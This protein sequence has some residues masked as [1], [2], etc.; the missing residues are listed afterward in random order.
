MQNMVSF[1]FIPVSSLPM[2]S[3]FADISEQEVIS[4]EFTD[5]PDGV[6]TNFG[7]RFETF[8]Y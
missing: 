5:D 6:T 7:S 4:F 8:G 2:Y 3:W 1:D